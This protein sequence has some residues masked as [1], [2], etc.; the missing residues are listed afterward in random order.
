MNKETYEALKRVMSG[1]YGK[2]SMQNKQD[3][4]QVETWIDEVEKEYD[5]EEENP[6]EL[7]EKAE[8]IRDGLR[9]EGINA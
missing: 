3:I 1:K 8:A 5:E 7:A 9:E 2:K 6:E 4:A